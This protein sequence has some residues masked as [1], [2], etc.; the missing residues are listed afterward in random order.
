[1][2]CKVHYLGV[3]GQAHDRFN[4]NIVECKASLMWAYFTP[5]AVL[6]ETLWNVKLVHSALCCRSASGFNRNIVE[7]KV[8]YYTVNHRKIQG[9]NRNIV[10]CKAFPPRFSISSI[11]FNRNIVECKAVQILEKW[12]IERGFNR[13]IVE[14][15][16]CLDSSSSFC[17]RVLIETLWNVKIKK[18]STIKNRN[19]F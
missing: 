5:A 8:N 11:R 7:C 6:I 2:E 13:N 18:L 10:E 1:M 4:R 15:K 12:E 17:C 3:D 9:F 14:C 19:K 16:A